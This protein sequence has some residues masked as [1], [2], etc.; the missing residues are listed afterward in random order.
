M[1]D[2]AV[3]EGAI[4]VLMME[5][6]Q[7]LKLQLP[8]VPRWLSQKLSNEATR[9]VCISGEYTI[10]GTFFLLTDIL[11]VGYNSQEVLQQINKLCGLG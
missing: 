11:S 8:P 10:F 4:S 5:L 9:L 6:V 1:E 7:N 3:H 2:I